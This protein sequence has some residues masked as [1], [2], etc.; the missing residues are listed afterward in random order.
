MFEH[1]K[2]GD[3]V[4]RLLA[5]VAPMTLVVSRVDAEFI[6]CGNWIFRRDT[7]GEVD[8]DLGWDGVRVTGS[9]LQ[10]E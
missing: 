7:G 5:G 2:A 6:Y 10:P 9:V 4:T 8:F 1:K 3:T